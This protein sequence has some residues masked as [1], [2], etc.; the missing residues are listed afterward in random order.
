MILPPD[1]SLVL[2][3]SDDG[4]M[5][6]DASARAWDGTQGDLLRLLPAVYRRGT[7]VDRDAVLGMLADVA[8]LVWARTSFTMEAGASPRFADE[9]WLAEWGDTLGRRQQPGETSA[10]YRQRLLQRFATITPAAIKGA[11]DALVAAYT[12]RH[13]VYLEPAVDAAYCAPASTA[14][15]VV[16]NSNNDPTAASYTGQVHAK[17]PVWAAFAQPVAGG[18]TEN[19]SV[20]AN[21]TRRLL[22]YYPDQALNPTPPSYAVPLTTGGEFWILPPADSADDSATPHAQPTT[23]SPTTGVFNGDY[24][25]AAPATSSDAVVENSNN[26]STSSTYGTQS[27]H[28]VVP[29]WA[30]G[31][32]TRPGLS[33][34]EQIISEV[35]RRIA[36]GTNWR[37]IY[38]PALPNAI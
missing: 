14:D 18:T 3:D 33:L 7:L 38:D 26:D 25:F 11:V 19:I 28:G 4:S 1:D 31:Y 23:D 22:S 5:V 8:M 10:A 37:L 35:E 2:P 30:Y 12:A 20:Y 21:L 16:Q 9:P 29:A 27:A 36:A 34:G 13:A 15:T 6:V 17:V 32:T 24:D